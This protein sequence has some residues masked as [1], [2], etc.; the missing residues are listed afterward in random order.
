MAHRNKLKLL[1]AG[2]LLLAGF[3][4]STQAVS[5]AT[6][7]GLQIAPLRTKP[8][9]SPG[10]TTPAKIT[11]TN[12]ETDSQDVT[13][14]VQRFN[15]V[16]EVYDYKFQDDPSTS[17]IRFPENQISIASGQKVELP[18]SI[19]VPANASP[20][21]YYFAIFA[22]IESGSGS[23]SLKEV[24]R[25]GSLVYLEVAGNVS[26]KG[27]V[28][29]FDLPYVSF[30]R[31][32][33][34]TIRLANQGNTHF[35]ADVRFAVGGSEQEGAAVKGLLLPGTVRRLEGSI[36]MPTL[37]GLYK[38]TARYSSTGASTETVSSIILYAPY[39]SIV[40]VIVIFVGGILYLIRRKKKT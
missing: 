10:D 13:I 18:Y 20:G 12:L 5:A 26:K 2:L 1:F 27:T 17:W 14:S 23:E 40:V 11:L 25:V 33:P 15:T 32:V 3:A 30:S 22:S 35:D 6:A 29:S 38:V 39:W 19:A 28:S 37:P 34:M 8:S 24:K 9:L 31:K 36:T 16:N 4:V 7:P 21:G